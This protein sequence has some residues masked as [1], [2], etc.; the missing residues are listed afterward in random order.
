[1]HPNYTPPLRDLSSPA[2][3]SEREQGSPV[4]A[5]LPRLDNV[6]A[7]GNGWSAR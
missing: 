6:R 2:E 5:L 3:R 4:G 1:V 7:S